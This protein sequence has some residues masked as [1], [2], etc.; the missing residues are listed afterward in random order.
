MV[1]SPKKPKFKVQSMGVSLSST[2]TIKNVCAECGEFPHSH[3]SAYLPNYWMDPR[4]SQMIFDWYKKFIKRMNSDWYKSHKPRHFFNMR[5]FNFSW[6]EKSYTPALHQHADIDQM[7]N[8]VDYLIC[9][10]GKSV[11][12]F[13]QTSSQNRPEI[14]NR[15]ARYSYPRKFQSY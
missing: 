13:A 5:N 11:W 8:V 10:C 14:R 4:S 2:F 7:M 1:R 12:A 15:K 6:M 9:P 3:Y